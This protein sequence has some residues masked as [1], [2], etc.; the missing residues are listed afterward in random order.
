MMFKRDLLLLPTIQPS[1]RMFYSRSFSRITLFVGFAL[2]MTG[3]L[4][5]ASCKK[6]KT[7]ETT[8]PPI[9]IKGS[10]LLNGAYTTFTR[11]SYYIT[12]TEELSNYLV[13]F[14]SDNSSITMRFPGTEEGVHDLGQGDSLVS[15]QYKDAGSRLFN[16]DSGRIMVS[17]YSIKEGVFTI[18]GG[19]EFHAKRLEQAGDTTFYSHIRG[20]EGGFIK[21]SSQE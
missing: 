21:I 4:S 16:A 3:A 7:E 12:G 6:D 5:L 13:L 14:R 11:Y 2:L 10:F 17:D 18:S 20:F 9:E 1:I 19:F 15:L 8:T